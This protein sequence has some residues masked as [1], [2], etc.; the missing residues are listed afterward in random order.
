MANIGRHVSCLL[1]KDLL[2]QL[3]QAKVSHCYKEANFCIDALAKLGASSSDGGSRFAAP[4]AVVNPFLLFDSMGLYRNRLCPNGC[5]T[6]PGWSLMKSVI[7]QKKKKSFMPTKKCK[8]LSIFFF[9]FLIVP[10]CVTI[11]FPLFVGVV[12]IVANTIKFNQ[13]YHISNQMFLT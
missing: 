2:L 1:C 12:L 3:P 10:L 11:F 8:Y 7:Y 6:I 13:K 9:T 5:E 4:L